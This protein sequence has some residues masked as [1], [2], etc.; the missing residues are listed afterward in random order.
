MSEK[1]SSSGKRPAQSSMP[2]S[3]SATAKSGKMN[4][5]RIQI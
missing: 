3:S 2:V 1:S 4:V 5:R